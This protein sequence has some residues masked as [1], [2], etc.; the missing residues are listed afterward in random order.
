M[1]DEIPT[2]QEMRQ[3]LYQLGFDIR[4]LGAIDV[5]APIVRQCL[6]LQRRDGLSGED[7]YTMMAWHLMEAA[8]VYAKALHEHAVMAPPPRVIVSG[9]HISLPIE[10]APKDRAI[11]LLMPELREVWARGWWRGSWSHVHTCWT[12]HLPFEAGPNKALSM[13][14]SGK[15]DPQPECW[16]EL[17]PCP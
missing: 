10:T 14:L 7:T 6:Q 4:G 12:L 15:R 8:N 11:M 3:R 9:G 13:P 16:T 5:A 17:P 1:P 2:P